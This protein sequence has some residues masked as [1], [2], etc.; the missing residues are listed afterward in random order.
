I[1]EKFAVEDDADIACLIAD[2]LPTIQ[3]AD[4]AETPRRQ[5]D[6]GPDEEPVFIGSAMHQRGSHGVERAHRHWAFVGEIDHARDAAHGAP[7]R[8]CPAQIYRNAHTMPRPCNPGA[9][10]TACTFL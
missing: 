5:T 10:H 9:R 7:L 6:A 3:E 8:N 4:D 1:V 2:W